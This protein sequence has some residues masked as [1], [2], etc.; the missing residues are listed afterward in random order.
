MKAEMLFRWL[1]NIVSLHW[2]F[3]IELFCFIRIF[4]V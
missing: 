1:L 2:K 4:F 3:F